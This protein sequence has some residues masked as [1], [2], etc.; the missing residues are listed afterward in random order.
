[1]RESVSPFQLQA[2]SWRRALIQAVCLDAV[3]LGAALW[4]FSSSTGADSPLGFYIALVVQ[5]PAS[6]LFQP[7]LTAVT[8]L[9]ASDSTA[10]T[11]AAAGVALL[12]FVILA[13]V[14]KRPWRSR[15]FPSNNRWRGP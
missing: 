15:A 7:M 13:L 6:L 10:M 8:R 5:F 4:V 14:L 9:G 1:M 12:E 11:T 2:I 3:L